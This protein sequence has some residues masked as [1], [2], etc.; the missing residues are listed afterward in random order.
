MSFL[1]VTSHIHRTIYTFN[2]FPSD[3]ENDVEEQSVGIIATRFYI[4]FLFIGV[5][6]LGFYTSLAKRTQTS[7]VI[8]PSLSEF[9][10]LQSLHSSTLICSCSRFS[11]SYRRIIAISPQYHQICSSEFLEKTW[12]SYFELKEVKP[13]TTLFT[14]VDFRI[15]GQSFFT[16]MRDLCKFSKVTVDNAIRSFQSDRLVTVNALS[17]T[18][19]N[20]EI[21]TRFKQFEQQTIASFVNLLELIRS[22]IQTNRLVSSLLNDVGLS[23]SFNKLTSKWSPILHYR[24][25]ENSSCSCAYSS[26]CTRP[27]GFYLQSDDR[28]INPRIIIPGLVIGCYTI[29]SLLFSTLEC[30]YEQKCVKLLLDMYYFDAVGLLKPLN[31]RTTRIQ[32]LH[33]D[34]SRFSPNTTV[35]SILAQLFIEHWNTSENFTAYYRQCAPKQCTYSII[36]RFD[37]AYMIAMMLGFYSGLSAILEIILPSLVRSIRR[38]WKRQQHNTDS[39]EITGKKISWHQRCL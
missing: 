31:T 19:F 7:T 15:S 25:V 16:L 32:S 3:D 5:I 14:G 34:N 27:Q 8:S 2:L 11:M 20:D 26:Q 37:T 36:R 35:E 18:Q 12:L 6:I 23:S 10:K 9:N 30:L 33:K 21:K 22:S 24:D 29:D 17:H 1:V 28:D 13:N 38:R 39:L 4:L